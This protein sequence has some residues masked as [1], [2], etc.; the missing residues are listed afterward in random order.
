MKRLKRLGRMFFEED[1]GSGGGG[2]SAKGNEPGASGAGDPNNTVLSGTMIEKVDPVSKKT[3]RIPVEYDAYIGHMVS[4]TRKTTEGQY[5]PIIEKLESDTAA[6]GEIKAEVA[7]LREANMT[8]EEKAQANASR[9]ISDAEVKMKNA[10][11]EVGVW[12]N[13][14]QD[15]MITNQIMASFGDTKLCN[16]EQTA[17]LF[18][19][20]GKAEVVDV[21]GSDGKP[22]GGFETRLKLNLI[23][24]KSGELEAL[25][26]TPKELFTRWV[27]EGR[28]L[29][30]QANNLTPG[31]GSSSGHRTTS[32]EDIM[33]L[34][35]V[36]RM[37]RARDK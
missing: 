37:K 1:D 30:H 14:F 21:I 10:I 6:F 36:E 3:I 17:I 16:P 25:E 9:K 8:A 4:T 2:T 33:K 35:P 12:R 28:N 15:T 24:D 11:N 32:R 34:P 31:A 18:R 7:K 23:N 5:K 13:R 26:G 22:T 19:N 29:H 27:S 20:E